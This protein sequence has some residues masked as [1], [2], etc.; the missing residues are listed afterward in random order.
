MERL[1]VLDALIAA[2]Y[3]D[4]QRHRMPEAALKAA[5]AG[6]EIGSRGR[7]KGG[8]SP[9]RAAQMREYSRRRYE[10]Q[11]GLDRSKLGQ[12]SRVA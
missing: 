3:G 7:A 12:R 4:Y 6:E 11:L 5:E 1:K 10:K 8:P 9:K 2:G